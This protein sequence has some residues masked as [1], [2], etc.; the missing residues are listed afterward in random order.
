MSR[1]QNENIKLNF[2]LPQAGI[3]IAKRIGISLLNKKR[4]YIVKLP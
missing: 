4:C 3:P 1:R 2:R